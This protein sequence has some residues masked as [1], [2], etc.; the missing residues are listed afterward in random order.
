MIEDGK[1]DGL[2]DVQKKHLLGNRSPT[3]NL[4]FPVQTFSDKSKKDNMRKCYR[5]SS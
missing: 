5:E 2:S 4:E 1:I 3:P